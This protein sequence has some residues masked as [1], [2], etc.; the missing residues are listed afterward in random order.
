MENNEIRISRFDDIRDKD[1]YQLRKALYENEK[2][3]S[4]LYNE[5]EM[6]VITDRLDKLS[7]EV[8]YEIYNRYEQFEKLLGKYWEVYMIDSEGKEELMMY[9]YPYMINKVNDYMF[10]LV[11]WAD[12][13]YG[14]KGGISEESFDILSSHIFGKC[15]LL[16]KP[17]T[18]EKLMEEAKKRCEENLEYR[19]AR[20]KD[21]Q[22]HPEKYSAVVVNSFRK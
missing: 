13:C 19:L 11:T 10:T 17:T 16:F 6:N 3:F 8:N 14:N 18:K 20:E 5:D 21:K 22:E 1:V 7:E 12:R 4:R 15:D 9:I 2:S